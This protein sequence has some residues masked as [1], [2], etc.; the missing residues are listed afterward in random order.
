MPYHRVVVKAECIF[1]IRTSLEAEYS[2]YSYKGFIPW[3][4]YVFLILERELI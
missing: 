3:D 2:D 4:D 1:D